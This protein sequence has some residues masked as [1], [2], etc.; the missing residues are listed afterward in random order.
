M[1]F[2]QSLKIGKERKEETLLVAGGFSPKHIKNGYFQG[3]CVA[4]TFLIFLIID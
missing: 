4:L 2:L 3:M 1:L